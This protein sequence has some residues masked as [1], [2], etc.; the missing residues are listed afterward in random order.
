M[1]CTF[2]FIFLEH[3]NEVTCN[4]EGTNTCQYSSNC[5]VGSKYQWSRQRGTTPS[6]DTGPSGDADG[7]SEGKKIAI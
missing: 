1:C 7:F 2:F 6:K 4:F 5:T 3:L